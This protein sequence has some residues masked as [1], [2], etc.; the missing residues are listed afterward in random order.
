MDA[1]LERT[2]RAPRG[3]LFAGDAFLLVSSSAPGS[4]TSASKDSGVGTPSDAAAELKEL[5]VANGGRVV[6]TEMESTATA[7]SGRERVIVALVNQ[8]LVVEQLAAEDVAMIARM[9]ASA[10]RDVAA[11]VLRAQWIRD[12]VTQ[13]KRLAYHSYDQSKSILALARKEQSAGGDNI[14][15][16]HT[17]AVGVQDTK[18]Q[19][20]K[21]QKIESEEPS[22]SSALAPSIDD[23]PQPNFT[24]W[25]ESNGGSLLI[26]DARSKE[27]QEAVAGDRTLKIAGFDMD[28]TWIETKSGKRFAKDVND[29]KWLHPTLVKAK[30]EELMKA[31]F[32]IVLFSNQNGIAK[33]NVTAN[34]V[35]K[36]VETIITKLNLPVLALLATQNDLMRKPRLGGWQEML[37]ILGVENPDQQVDMTESFYCGDAAGR[38]KIAGRNKDFAATDYKFALNIGVKFHTPEDLFLKSK[39]RIHTHTDMWEIGF[40]PRPLC[41]S[42]HP[43]TAELTKA[44]QEIIVLVGPPASG[45]SFF[46]KTHF[47][48]YMIVNQDELGTVANCKKKCMEALAQKKSVIVDSTNRDQRARSEWISI[49]K[50]QYCWGVDKAYDFMVTKRADIKLDE[51]YAEQLCSLESQLQKTY[52]NRATEQQIFEWNPAIVDPKTDELVLVHTLLNAT[53]KPNGHTTIGN[54]KK[55]LSAR[56]TR[57]ITWIDQS[58]EMV[59]WDGYL[60]AKK[61]HPSLLAKPERPPNN[62]YSSMYPDNGWVDVLNPNNHPGAHIDQGHPH[63]H[64]VR[65][66]TGGSDR[67]HASAVS[68]AFSTPPDFSSKSR[69]SAFRQQEN[70]FPDSELETV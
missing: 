43:P 70:A 61:L 37:K 67:E 60:F 10:S 45:K 38:P 35:K 23:I 55:K 5:I 26:L 15:A 16:T 25:R 54:P 36:K 30:L 4:S 12:C 52:P 3:Q 49:A 31:G 22:P 40:D 14:Q 33:G 46:S 53:S 34:E 63:A 58:T 27:K 28:G 7:S 65:D 69:Q 56:A 6:A 62:S 13:Q 19:P 1:F 2:H 47:S 48:S 44:D 21:K 39:Q 64:T 18:E 66:A 24:P 59:L 29:W 57:R 9:L 32:E 42:N 51:S 17:Q 20:N 8:P 41:D 68:D 11:L 50:Q